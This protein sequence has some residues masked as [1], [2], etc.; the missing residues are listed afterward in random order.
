[1][2]KIRSSFNENLKLELKNIDYVN[3][4]P[5]ILDPY[6]VLK[7][8][9]NPSKKET[10]LAFKKQLSNTN[11]S[12]TCL[13]YEM[14]CNSTNFIKIDNTFMYKVKKKINFIMLMLEA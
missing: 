9:H 13:A 6:K 7:I 11:R 12:S 14:I 3:K 5:E 8:S 4:Y 2:R 1:M 10:K